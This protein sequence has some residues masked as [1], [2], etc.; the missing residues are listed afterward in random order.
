MFSGQC[1]YVR[2]TRPTSVPHLRSSSETL[3][4]DGLP[5]ALLKD[6]IMEE[7]LHVSFRLWDVMGRYLSLQ[8]RLANCLRQS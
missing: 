1:F 7:L 3:D 6:D 2:S 4:S 5:P 8:M